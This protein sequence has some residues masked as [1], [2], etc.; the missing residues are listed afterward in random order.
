M[1]QYAQNELLSITE[2]TKKLAS[3]VKSIKEEAIEKIGILKNN[4][5]EAVLIS[6]SEYER[7]KHFEALI[8]EQEDEELSK[9]INERQS[10]P[11]KTISQEDLLKS[12]NIKPDELN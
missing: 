3:M 4:K 10:K 2:F 5:L 6:T 12:L 11:Y 1:V 9:V 7:L 8:E